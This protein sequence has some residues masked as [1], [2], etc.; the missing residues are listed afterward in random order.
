MY[1]TEW[2]VLST[3]ALCP[4]KHTSGYSVLGTIAQ[5]IVPSVLYLVPAPCSLLAPTL[6]SSRPALRLQP[7]C[8]SQLLTLL[9][10]AAM[11]TWRWT[12]FSDYTTSVPIT[13]SLPLSTVDI[14][15]GAYDELP[16]QILLL[17][18][19][20]PP[21]QSQRETICTSWLWLLGCNWN[22]GRFF[23]VWVEPNQDK[24]SPSIVGCKRHPHWIWHQN[25]YCNARDPPSMA[26]FKC[27]DNQSLLI[28]PFWIVSLRKS[29]LKIQGEKEGKELNKG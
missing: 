9:T 5:C 3:S 19:R 12:N 10:L 8:A 14:G 25:C 13:T 29:I 6:N 21:I 24:P 16:F 17:M 7:R 2:I 26:L 23:L 11:L 18:L 22:V 1:S 15:S 4:L 27:T 28:L 20:I